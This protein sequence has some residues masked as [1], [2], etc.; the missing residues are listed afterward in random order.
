MDFYPSAKKQV[1]KIRCSDGR[2]RK[3]DELHGHF[4]HQVRLPGGVLF[5]DL[6]AMHFFT[7][8]HQQKVASKLLRRVL[9]YAIRVTIDLKSPSEIILMSHTLC[10]AAGVLGLSEEDVKNAYIEWGESL[11]KHFPHIPV[12]VLHERHS[13]CGEHHQGHELLQNAA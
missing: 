12:R 8:T 1:L 5:P 6:C 2:S 7:G 4:V 11:K 3:P 9:M 13:E 10:G